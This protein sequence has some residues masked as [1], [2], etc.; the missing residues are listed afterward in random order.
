MRNT[1]REY[2]LNGNS[3]A[4][5]DV[6]EEGAALLEELEDG[7]LD[8]RLLLEYFCGIPAHRLLSDPM[9]EVGAEAREAFLTGV[10]R[11]ASREPLAYITGEQSFMG[12]PFVVSP[13]VLIPEQ[14]TENLVEEALRHLED[15]SRILDLCT[16]SGCILLSLLRYTN[17]CVGVGTDI[18]ERALN[19][20]AQNA[21]ALDLADRAAWLQ[22]DLFEALAAV[23]ERPGTLFGEGFSLP[24]KYDMIISN[25]PYIRT[26]VIETLEPEVRLSEPRAALDG[27]EDGLDFYRRIILKA[28][29]HL[30]IGGRL[31]LEIG[32]DQ[33]AD[34]TDLLQ[35]AGYYGIEIIK[36][37]GGNDRVVTAVRSIRQT[38]EKDI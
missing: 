2:G 20:A 1:N 22:G 25:P 37:Y 15:G 24:E 12:L 28:P 11:R 33:A 36:D 16:G 10:R 26:D 4:C 27:G 6:Y 8:A 32:H 7:R 34:V 35:E 19:I 17:S 31:M 23:P 13:D 5:R 29:A 14:D 18:S 30:V 21:A 3:L 38:S 9:L